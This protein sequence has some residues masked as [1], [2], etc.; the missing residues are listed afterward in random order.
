ML[1]EELNLPSSHG[2]SSQAV[3]HVLHWLRL[4]GQKHGRTIPPSRGMTSG[5]AAVSGAYDA[6]CK[7]RPFN[8]TVYLRIYDTGTLSNMKTSPHGAGLSAGSACLPRGKCEAAG[9]ALRRACSVPRGSADAGRTIDDTMCGSFGQC[10]G[11][12]FAGRRCGMEHRAYASSQMSTRRWFAQDV[13]RGH[14]QCT[15]LNAKICMSLT[16]V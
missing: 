7:L 8:A 9:Q 2:G 12:V 5:S 11:R 14:L 1:W 6:H 4:A 3:N 13:V 15:V 16:S 10:S